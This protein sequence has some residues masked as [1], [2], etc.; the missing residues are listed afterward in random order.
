MIIMKIN[1]D[2]NKKKEKGIKVGVLSKG[3]NKSGDLVIKY[4]SIIYSGW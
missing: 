4:T 3:L 2:G 1:P